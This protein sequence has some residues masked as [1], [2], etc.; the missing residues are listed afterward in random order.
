MARL[1]EVAARDCRAKTTTVLAV[2]GGTE[3]SESSYSTGNYGVGQHYSRAENRNN[4]G[5]F[6]SFRTSTDRGGRGGNNNNGHQVRIK[7]S[8][9]NCGKDWAS[10]ER[11]LV[12]E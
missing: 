9:W 10:T 4:R 8:C 2:G 12:P 11:L 1:S 7:G 6:N 5:S 3:F